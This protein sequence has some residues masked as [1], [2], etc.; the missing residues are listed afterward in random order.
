MGDLLC[1]SFIIPFIQIKSDV[2]GSTPHPHE[3]LDRC[4]VTHHFIHSTLLIPGRTSFWR[5]CGKYFTRQRPSDWAKMTW[6]SAVVPHAR[7]SLLG[8]NVAQAIWTQW[9]GRR[10]SLTLSAQVPPKCTQK[11]PSL[12]P[13]HRHVVAVYLT[14]S[15]EPT[16]PNVAAEVAAMICSP[17]FSSFHFSAER[18]GGRRGLVPLSSI[19]YPYGLTFRVCAKTVSCITR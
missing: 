8:W 9:T 6:Q 1:I 14:P 7:G 3:L 15:S 5:L 4:T 13:S 18:G 19:Y 11:K 17:L 16:S 12:A 10:A 2:P